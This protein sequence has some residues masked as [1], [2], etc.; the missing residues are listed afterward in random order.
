MK[1]VLAID[2]ESFIEKLNSLFEIRE[3]ILRQP[4]YSVSNSV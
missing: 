4:S 3:K 2:K 1:I